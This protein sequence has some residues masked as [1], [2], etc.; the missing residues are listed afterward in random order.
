MSRHTTRILGRVATTRPA[1]LL[2][3]LRKPFALWPIIRAYARPFVGGATRRKA[4]VAGSLRRQIP[5]WLLLAVLLI[6]VAAGFYISTAMS[7]A[8]SSGQSNSPDFSIGATP[9]SS[10]V[11]Q[12]QLATFTVSLNSLHSFAGSVNL[13]A[14]LSP[15]TINVTVALNPSSVSLLT[16]SGT[17]TLTVSTPATIPVGT[18][19]LTINGTSGR[20]AHSVHTFLQVTIPPSPDF[21]VIASPASLTLSTGSSGSSTLTFTSQAGFSGVISLAA[22]VTPNGSNSPTMMMNPSTVTLLSGGTSSAVLTMSTVSNT[23]RTIYTIVVLATSG[24]ISHT[25]SVYLTVQ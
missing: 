7:Q 14:S 13:N 18:Y 9:S 23:P 1:R 21:L 15:K 10:P 19:T 16:G 12:G 2:K 3:R 4:L 24:S 20:L 6:G 17:S 5:S 25:V 11:A 8:V 22:T